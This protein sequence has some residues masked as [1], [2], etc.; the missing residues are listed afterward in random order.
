MSIEV[1]PIDIPDSPTAETRSFLRVLNLAP[2]AT[3]KPVSPSYEAFSRISA[4]V[5]SGTVV[6]STEGQ[7]TGI[8]IASTDPLFVLYQSN[9]PRRKLALRDLF[10]SG[11]STPA[12]T[13]WCEQ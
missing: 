5:T 8:S 13:L 12:V 7:E 1:S 9:D 2:V 4:K 10:I 6:F 3:V 11:S